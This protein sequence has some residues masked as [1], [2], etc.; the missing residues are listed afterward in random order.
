[1]KDIEKTSLDF[2]HTTCNWNYHVPY[3]LLVAFEDYLKTPHS[4]MKWY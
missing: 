1:M 3:P 4:V 2:A